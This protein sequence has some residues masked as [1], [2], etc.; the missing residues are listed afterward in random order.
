MQ[1]SI[2]LMLGTLHQ[3]VTILTKRGKIAYIINNRLHILQS[4][5][6]LVDM[7]HY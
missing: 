3:A 6:Q 4:K 7:S 2:Y 1:F 5:K